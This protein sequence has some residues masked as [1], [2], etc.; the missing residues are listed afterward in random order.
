MATLGEYM[1][2]LRGQG[3]ECRAGIAADPTRGMVPVTKL[4]SPD[5]RYVIHPGSDQFEVLSRY[6]IEYFDRRLQ[7]ASPF[8]SVPRA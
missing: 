2:W 1:G 4:I 6:T 7:M 5:G 8:V 3:G